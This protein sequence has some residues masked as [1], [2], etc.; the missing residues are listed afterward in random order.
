MSYKDIKCDT[1]ADQCH[2]EIFSKS[3]LY[4]KNSFKKYASK[5]EKQIPKMDKT[6]KITVFL[7][8][9]VE[10]DNKWRKEIKKEFGDKLFFLDPYDT[11]WKPEYNIYDEIVSM[12]KSDYVIFYKPGKISKKE[13]EFLD[14][15]DRD[16]E[17][18]T[19]IED[20]KDYL[21]AVSKPIK[22]ACIN[23]YLYKQSSILFLKNALN[24]NLEK[25]I[26]KADDMSGKVHREKEKR[27]ILNS[28]PEECKGKNPIIIKQGILR[29]AKNDGDIISYAR[30]RMKKEPG[31]DPQYSLGVKNFKL[32]QESET[33][34]SKQMFDSFYPDFLEK[35]QEKKRY[36]LSNGWE[37]DLMEDK[38]VAE[39]EQKPGEKV[40]IP[41]QWDVKE[42]KNYKMA[43]GGYD[44]SSLQI[45][46]PV[47]IANKIKSIGNDIPKKELTGS[48]LE[49]DCHITVLYGFL[50]TDPEGVKKF[51]K[52]TKQFDVSII[53]TDLFTTSPLF[54]VVM[55]KVNSPELH[56]LNK[57]LRR[58]FAHR[59]T[60]SEYNP[61]ATI[62]YVKKGYGPKYLG[63]KINKNFVAKEFVFSS[64]NG[65]RTTIR[66]D[67]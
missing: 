34:I 60:H 21:K 53:G 42:E 46:V 24:I 13:K 1:K 59:S 37:I 36:K 61:H 55:L 18:F 47:S 33:E 51:L 22:K 52:N 40:K 65:K 30:I 38:I 29:E 27:V 12:E 67:K 66:L 26:K 15:T 58:N 49:D 14:T 4:L 62:A 8:G 9:T 23:K 54:D 6:K 56:R 44:Y 50:D 64:S 2:S 28:L 7:G 39:Y 20:L 57:E 63:K 3:Q 32:S 19:N 16:Y 10:D 41:K 17:E 48:G 35:P 25:F 31:K 5:L 43:S 45:Q 11:R